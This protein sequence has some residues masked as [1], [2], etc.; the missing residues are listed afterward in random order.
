MNQLM[1]SLQKIASGKQAA[2][3]IFTI[4]DRERKIKS[5]PNAIIPETF[6]GA[7]RFEDVTFAYPKNKAQNVLSDLSC[8]IQNTSC[9]FVGKSGCGKSTIFQLLLRFYDP[10][11]GRVT[12]DGHDLRDLDLEWLRRQIGFVGQEPVLF[13]TTVRE[14]MKMGRPDATDEQITAAL[15]Q[16]EA[17]SFVSKSPEK[18]DTFVG[19][20]GSQVSGGQKQRIAIARALLKN[21]KILLLDEATSSL[22]RKNEILIQGTISKIAQ[23]RTIIT[24]A[25]TITT[26]VNCER[27]FVVNDGKI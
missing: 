7:F 8:E 3:R 17:W 22:D 27:I 12:L 21:P 19:S 16:A 6:V 10:D 1:P 14:N 20:G 9:A 24:I 2:A 15:E 26:I 18:L 25:H 4:I 5:K 13:A 11:R 23:N